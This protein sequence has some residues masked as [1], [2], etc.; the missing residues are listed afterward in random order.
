MKKI[1]L[2][3]ILSTSFSLFAQEK[4]STK[5]TDML[6]HVV[7][8]GETLFSISRKYHVRVRKIKKKNNLKKNKIEIGQVLIIKE[9]ENTEIE[10][11]EEVTETAIANP[12]I[13]RN[14]SIPVI[15]IDTT[16]ITIEPPK[17]IW[18]DNYYEAKRIAKDE[19]KILLL[20]FT[21]SDWCGICKM[22]KSHFFESPEFIDI[23]N[24]DL[25]LYEADFPRRS[26]Y[27]S[28]ERENTNWAI[29]A[30]YHAHD[31]VPLVILI[32]SDGKELG[33]RY[34]FGIDG[35]TYYHF[36]LLQDALIMHNNK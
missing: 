31:G 22:L 9:I 27:L 13:E 23:A 28:E 20:F 1:L 5:E 7:K 25:V 35:D 3:I 11:P 36:K 16:S 33:R 2:I 4:D 17:S 14:D 10:I 32:D 30:E 24:K 12:I 21:G 18:T 19:N 29:K 34:N 26:N 15:A 6:T 8:K